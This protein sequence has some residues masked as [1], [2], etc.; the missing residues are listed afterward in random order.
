MVK[1]TGGYVPPERRRR[2]CHLASTER[3]EISRGL[4]RG[5][6]IRAIAR[7]LGRAPS[8]ISR[9][10]TR[11]KGRRTYRAVDADDRAWRRA[12]RPQRCLLSRQPALRDYV[13][14]RLAADWSPEQIAGVLAKEQPVG[15]GVTV[16]H[17]TIYKSLLLQPSSGAYRL[18]PES[19]VD[20]G[21][22]RLSV[23]V[24][25]GKKRRV[26]P[27]SLEDPLEVDRA[28]NRGPQGSCLR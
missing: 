20:L 28:G 9:E 13:A 12:R 14:D 26:S 3:E 15:E 17:E 19:A 24:G 5:E 27:R 7:Q 22:C 11:N 10:V 18:I 2:D 6:S 25:V 4:A 8:T 23:S 21:V 1:Q 16:S